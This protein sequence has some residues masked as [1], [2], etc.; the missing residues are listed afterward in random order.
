[1]RR[2]ISSA[3][4]IFCA[5]FVSCNTEDG[6]DQYAQWQK[7]VAAIDAYLTSN[8]I[9]AEKDA[10]G[11][12]MVIEELGTGLPATTL[13]TVQ[14]DYVGKL[15]STGAG[16]DSG[17]AN[18]VLS[19]FIEGWQF[20][21]TTLPAGSKAKIYIPSVYAYGQAGSAAIPANSTLVFDVHFKSVVLTTTEVERF[22]TDTTAIDAYLAQKGINAVTD[23]TG[24]RYVVTEPGTGTPPDWYDRMK[25]TYGIKL[26]TSDNQYVAQI[27]AE[28]SAGFDSRT[29]DY[30]LGM[31]V[32]LQKIGEGGKATLYIPSRLAFGTA[33]ASANG[34][35]VVPANANIIIEVEIHD[36]R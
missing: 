11:I 5:V 1:M 15:F 2:P 20:A 33:G 36:I 10:R 13:S 14:V 3:L 21:M 32:G 17:S 30:V 23:S 19:R 35:Q 31:M 4:I 25:L 7:E 26:L 24:V 8:N 18:G 16:F 12:R 6:F 27:T 29:V 22:R 28:P 9:T 34:V